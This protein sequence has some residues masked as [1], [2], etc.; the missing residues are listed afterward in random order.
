MIL[1]K[2]AKIA[3]EVC[4]FA[5]EIK[6]SKTWAGLYEDELRALRLRAVGNPLLLFEGKG[7]NKAILTVIVLFYNGAGHVK[8]ESAGH[9]PMNSLYIWLIAEQKG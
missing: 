9:F 7:N 8:K 2:L 3:Q 5:Q 6:S 1:V 4:T